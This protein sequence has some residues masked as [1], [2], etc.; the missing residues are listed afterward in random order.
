MD[1]IAVIAQKGGTGKTTVA[2]SLA[3]EAQ[4]VGKTAAIVDL[5]PQATATNWSDRRQ[6][7]DGQP[8]VVSAQAA[9]LSRVLK[10]AEEGGA[11]LV[12]IDTPAKASEVALAAV[13]AADMVLIPCRPAVFDLDTVQTTRD[14]IKTAGKP[15][16]ILAVLNG[17]PPRGSK[18]EQAEEVI[19]DHDIAVCPAVFGHRAAFSDAGALGLAA[20]EYD[21]TGKAAQE[22][23]EVYEYV[24]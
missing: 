16:P 18:R 5:D 13:R 1:V 3:V 15:V 6:G 17:V 22:T 12:L 11:D 10:S 19:K 4:R 23:K 20:Q 24:S 7:H 9:R 8:V 21:P 2:I 14:L